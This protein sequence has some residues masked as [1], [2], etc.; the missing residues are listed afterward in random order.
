MRISRRFRRFPCSDIKLL[1]GG[2]L[3]L[4]HRDGQ[5]RL[6]KR[7]PW[8]GSRSPCRGRLYF[9]GPRGRES[10]FLDPFRGGYE[11]LRISRRFGRDHSCRDGTGVSDRAVASPVVAAPMRCREV[12]WIVRRTAEADGDELIALERLGASGPKR[13]VDGK[14]ADMAWPGHGAQALDGVRAAASVRAP[15]VAAAHSTRLSL[16]HAQGS[17]CAPRPDA[18]PARDRRRR[19]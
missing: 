9:R 6:T 3:A 4:V 12:V 2:I 11:L 5:P 8:G 13:I 1:T 14:P 19:R 15:N 17:V 7:P 16:A 10:L 18:S